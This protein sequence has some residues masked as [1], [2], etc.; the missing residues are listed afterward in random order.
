M[1]LA[2]Y[3]KKGDKFQ[4]W[5]EN[6]HVHN[7]YLQIIAE[8][9]I[10]G[11]IIFCLLIYKII[12]AGYRLIITENDQFIN[13][14]RTGAYTAL[15]GFLLWSFAECS[16]TGEFSPLSF[17]HLNLIVILYINVILFKLPKTSAASLERSLNQNGYPV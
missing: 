16:Y 14:I 2:R 5:N 15:V 6:Y 1:H 17:F 8:C 10:V 13:G 3:R 12:V 4:W 7:L 9:G 11:F